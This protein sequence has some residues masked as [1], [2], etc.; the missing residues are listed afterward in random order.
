MVAADELGSGSTQAT[1]LSQDA[2]KDD[3]FW[4]A[5]NA[6]VKN[7]HGVISGHGTLFYLENSES[8]LTTNDYVAD[9]GNEWCKREPTKNVIFCFDKHS[10]FVYSTS[11]G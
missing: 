5:L 9:H 2:D 11:K 10:G 3:P 8:Q 7:L 6:Q 1:T 4:N